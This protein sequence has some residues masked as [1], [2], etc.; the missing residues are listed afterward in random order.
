MFILY[1]LGAGIVLGYGLGGRLDGLAAIRFRW[2]WLVALGL[3]VQ[4]VIFTPAGDAFVGAAGPA[5]YVASTAMVL[6]AIVANLRLPGLPLVAAGAL[7]NLAA[8]VANGGRMPADPAALASL[9][10]TNVGAATNSVIAPDPA[11]R[12]LTDLF[13]LPPWLPLANVFSIGDVLIGLGLAAAVAVA[14]RR[15]GRG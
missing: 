8:I 11:L 10:V 2:P 12:P 14:M 5:L 15:P 1:G 9:G 3:A 4:L 6:A 13:A 7:L